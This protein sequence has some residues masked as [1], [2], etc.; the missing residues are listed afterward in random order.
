MAA[1][2]DHLDGD[3]DRL[4]ARLAVQLAFVLDA[5]RLK[6]VE[7]RSTLAD[8]SRRENTAE[9][10]W[11]LALMALLLAEHAEPPV[12]V[13]KVVAMVVLHDLVEMEVGDT[14][15]YDEA[16]RVDKAAREAEAAEAIYG[17]LPPDQGSALLALWQEFEDKVT[18]EARFA[19]SLDRLEPLL[20][21]HASGG[22]TWREHGI[23]AAQVRD[24]NRRIADGSPALWRA[25]SELI[26]DAVATGS[27]P[28]GD[29]PPVDPA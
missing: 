9:H 28:S 3:E 6:S 24:L 1:T 19:G 16:A 14:F 18:P 22:G 15:V 5:D 20:L 17:R 4:A 13:A 21:N 8:G 12:D 26:D 11:H 25:A 29:Q 7:R 10:S 27:L 2:D 23:V